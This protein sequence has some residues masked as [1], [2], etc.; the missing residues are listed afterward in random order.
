MSSP[1]SVS[2]A[3]RTGVMLTPSRAA[4]SSS[5]I[6]SP[7]R[8]RPDMMRSRRWAATS[9][10]SCGRCS[11][12]GIAPP[13][14]PATVSNIKSGRLPM[15]GPLQ[16][17]RVIEL[18]GIGPGPFAA[19]H[20]ADLGADVLRIDRPGATPM[21][22]S[23]EHDLLTRGRRSVAVDLKHPEGPGTVLALA[24]RADVLLEGFRPGVTERLG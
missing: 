12:S 8:S 21:F 2:R 22:G 5:R 10:A 3:S 23:T 16:G 19:M 7:G 4:T 11:E 9:S 14:F 17:L 15:G 20:L 6:R 1:R 24:E 13:G 18:A